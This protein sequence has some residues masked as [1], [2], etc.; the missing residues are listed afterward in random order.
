MDQ[1]A[2]IPA[3]THR[4]PRVLFHG[5]LICLNFALYSSCPLL[6]PELLE[7]DCEKCHNKSCVLTKRFLTLPRVVVLQL[8]RHFDIAPLFFFM[9]PYSFPCSFESEGRRVVKRAERVALQTRLDFGMASSFCISFIS[10]LH[11]FQAQCWRTSCSLLFPF[12]KS[13]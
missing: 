5:M 13:V 10:H 8:K 7:R 11:V 6:Q 9:Y 1:E 12:P 3:H 4:S 2:R